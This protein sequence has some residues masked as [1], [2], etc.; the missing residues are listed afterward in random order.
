MP[1]TL[2]PSTPSRGGSS[3]STLIASMLGFFV[4]TLDAV[5]V[6]V[7]LP[8]LGNELSTGLSGLQWVVDGYTLMFAVLLL[9]AGALTDRFGARNTYGWG[10]F[11]FICA[12]LVC[13]LASN[14]SELVAARFAQGTAAAMMMPSSMALIGQAFP[15]PVMRGRAVGWW[16]MGG[17]VAAASGPLL[18]GLLLAVVSWR[19]I[20]WVNLP[21]GICALLLLRRTPSSAR[22]VAPFD[23]TGQVLAVIAMGAM[24]Y[25][26]IEGGALGP[27]HPTAIASLALAAIAGTGFV[28]EQ[29][30]V[31]H[32]MVPRAVFRQKNARLAIAVGFAFMACYFGLP[33][34]MSLYLQQQRGLSALATGEHFLPMMVVGLLLT[35]F[36]AR[37]V[38]RF[39]A[40]MLVVGGL[41]FMTVGLVA[42][43]VL[44]PIAPTGL[45]AGLMV[46]VGLGGPLVSP[47]ITAVLLHS[48]PAVLTGTASGVYNTSRQVGGALAVAVFGALL[49]QSTSFSA[50]MRASLLVAAGTALLTALAALQLSRPEA[51]LAAP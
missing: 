15:A 44:A 7:A 2:P 21:V 39:G 24:T 43:A 1:N 38:E 12:S 20:F 46:L 19:W 17:A 33:F 48:V 51:A 49:N 31:S 11:T 34:V 40:R 26:V 27:A 9:A 45:I 13:G 8:S 32:P 3:A 22:R 47:P 5:I 42:L 18:G 14:L 36:S 25:G 4:I 29:R 28:V 37:L 10:L 35:P 30:R 16:A 23:F 50:G 41:S 6:N